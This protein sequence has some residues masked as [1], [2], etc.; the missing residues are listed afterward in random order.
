MKTI[1]ALFVAFVF[2]PL[3]S[4]QDPRP[5]PAS[6]ADSLVEITSRASVFSSHELILMRAD[7]TFQDIVNDGVQNSVIGFQ[8][9]PP[10]S[11][12]YTYSTSQGPTGTEGLITFSGN[13][14]YGAIAFGGGSGGID[15]ASVN[16]YPRLAV[17]GAVNV[18]NNS[19]VEP[20]HPSTPGFVIQGTSPRWV[21][22]RG[23]GPSLAQFGVTNPVAAPALTLNGSALR[24][25]NL[26]TDSQNPN[27]GS[28]LPPQPVLPWSSDPNRV[29]GL[30]A[31]FSAAGAFQFQAGSADCAALVL[32]APGAYT[33]QAAT[34]GAAG[35]MLTEVYV[36]PYGN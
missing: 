34:S 32:L 21:L 23:D 28:P 3:L 1:I 2:A 14:D 4:A 10:L 27:Y 36:L 17:T 8:T 5:A 7:G 11:G 26:A 18:S 33:L 16:V 20:A 6:V 30:Q 12:T 24:S 9:F 15:S 35:E 29:A 25:V 22:I 31:L 13:K 19:W